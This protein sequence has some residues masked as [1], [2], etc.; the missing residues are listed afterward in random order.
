MS[1][2]PEANRYSHTPPPTPSS[3]R[4]SARLLLAPCAC[5]NRGAMV[6][7]T[8]LRDGRPLQSRR[9]PIRPRGNFRA[10]S[11]TRSL[12]FFHWRAL[13][14]PPED[15]RVFPQAHFVRRHCRT[16]ACFRRTQAHFCR[17]PSGAIQR[18][19]WNPFRSHRSQ[20]LHASS[21][22]CA[23]RLLVATSSR[24]MLPSQ[25]GYPA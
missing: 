12:C 18:T 23:A 2:T 16:R 5:Q 13:L 6:V 1:H 9:E 10:A 4:E 8:P 24:R 3:L 11:L 15:T 7:S 14:E 21:Q 17:A 20:D 25:W 22:A 19:K